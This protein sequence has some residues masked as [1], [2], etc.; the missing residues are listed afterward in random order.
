M[1]QTVDLFCKK[2]YGKFFPLSWP[3]IHMEVNLELA[4]GY[5]K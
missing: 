2:K 1:H 5:D 3:L 4:Q